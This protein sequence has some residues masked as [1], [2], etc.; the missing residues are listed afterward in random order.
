M[1]VQS[2]IT[3]ALTQ[4]KSL[5]SLSFQRHPE[6]P[7]FHQRAEGSPSSTHLYGLNTPNNEKFASRISSLIK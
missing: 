7:R 4:L 3:Q 1:S 2:R 6:G 5:A